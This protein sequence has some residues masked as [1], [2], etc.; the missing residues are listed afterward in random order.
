[1]A[2]DENST[3]AALDAARAVFRG[4]IEANQ[5]RV[6]DMAG[7][8]VLAVFETVTG[9][10][11]AALAIQETLSAA[12][13]TV[14][15]DRRMRFR[16]GVH[17]GDVIEKADGTVYGDGVNI[18]AR[19]EEM[20]QPG[21]ITVSAGVRGSLRG[22]VSATFEDQGEQ[23][24]KNIPEP[25]LAYRVKPAGRGTPTPIFAAA[26]IDLS[27]PD[28]P[29]IAVL[30]FANM[31]AD[32]E[33]DFFSDGMTED[34][35]TGLSR[36]PWLFVISRSSSFT[37]R[38]SAVD[39]KKV[40]RELGV[41]Y[42][43]EGSVRKVGDRVRVTAQLIDGITGT[44]V[45]AE[46]Y[47]GHLGDVFKLQ[48]DITQKVVAAIT[49]QILATMGSSSQRLE[50]P[51]VRTW[52][53]VMHGQR[54]LYELTKESIASAV[55]VFRQALASG[56]N[57]CEAH[58]GLAAVLFHSAWM[59]FSDRED[60]TISEAHDLIRRALILDDRNEYAHWA[61]GLIELWQRHHDVAVA[62]L[63]RAIELNPNCSLAYG[64]LGTVLSFCRKSDDA[65]K[66]SE[67]AIRTNPKDPSIFFRFSGIALAHYVAGRYE[68]AVSWAH[69]AIHRKSDWYLAH[70]LLA[71]SL[72]QLGRSKE[73][74]DAIDGLVQVTPG[75]TISTIGKLPFKFPE[76]AEHLSE[77]LRKAGLAE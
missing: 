26:G 73:A 42:V 24:V 68:D 74:R 76:D 53:L 20:A 15:E 4:Q 18:A 1:M 65:I 9:A 61:A 45:F 2:A 44:H 60:A 17:L 77:G 71:A 5:G 16:I 32:P 29:S 66:N 6:I 10:V 23:R 36:S 19:L 48:D 14:P 37:Y 28:K 62:Q 46:R 3:V 75:A 63:E 7:D 67:F 34:I 64:S 59:G 41:R 39:I 40:C 55:G 50:R 27:L 43:L 21:G 8:S 70:F 22:K 54:L 13:S 25:V 51:D 49:T 30:P 69:R 56:P 12:A 38:G 35:I 47:D 72:G 57:S 52:E 31:S 58:Y 33:Q 11:N